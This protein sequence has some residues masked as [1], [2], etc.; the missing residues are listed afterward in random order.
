MH[1]RIANGKRRKYLSEAD[2]GEAVRVVRLHGGRGFAENLA[3]L[4]VVPGA[5][6]RLVTRGRS[7]PVVIE[8]MGGRIAIGR[9]MAE[10]VEV[11]EVHPVP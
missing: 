9:S 2:S 10:R 6:V 4:G 1:T 5:T 7:G 3:R 8:C 11:T